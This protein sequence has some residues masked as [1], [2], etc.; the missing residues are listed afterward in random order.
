MFCLRVEVVVI[1]L[2]KVNVSDTQNDAVADVLRSGQLAA[3]R[4]TTELERRFSKLFEGTQC[5]AVANGTMGLMLAMVGV[6]VGPGHEVVTTAFSFFGTIEPILQLGARPVFV[7]VDIRTGNMD[8]SQ[9]EMAMSERTAAIL[10]VHLYGR[11]VSMVKL[12]KVA[13]AWNVPV[14][15]DA[16]QAIGAHHEDG[17]VVGGSGIAVFSFYGSKNITCGEGGLVA[18]SNCELAERIRLLRNHG[19]VTGYEHKVVGYN[20]RMTDIQAAL[21]LSEVDR[22]ED[23]TMARRE[24][25]RR[26]EEMITNVAVEKPPFVENDG[27]CWHQYTVRT[28]SE[29]E[30]GQLQAWAKQHEIETR[31]Y[32]PNALS[33]LPVVKSYGC[34]RVCPNAEQLSRTVLSVPV[35]ESLGREEVDR[36]A[37]MLSQWHPLVR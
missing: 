29:D 2:S 33:S 18:T 15:E 20:G 17:S 12:R 6:G 11:A 27:G 37:A 36:V 31:V 25:A 24:N 23:I 1:R 5:V 4:Q 7:D 28:R 26:Y 32:Y 16:C 22:I 19:S 30:R 8:T 21:L 9:V 3:G 35:R 10:P 14:I 34:A 13:E